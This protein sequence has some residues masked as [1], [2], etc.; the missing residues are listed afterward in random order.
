M[1]KVVVKYTFKQQINKIGLWIFDNEIHLIDEDLAP[2]DIAQVFSSDNKFIGQGYFNPTSKIVI[3][4]LSFDSNEIINATFFKQRITQC[5]QYRQKIGLSNNCRLVFAEGD[6]LPGLIIDKFNDYFVIQIY[7]L[8]M[9]KWKDTIIQIINEIFNPKGIYLRN[10]LPVRVLE[11][12]TEEK[13]SVGKEFNSQI[14]ID[15]HGLKFNVDVAFG[16]KT[17]YFL[18][19]HF[20]RAAIEPFV[21]NADVLSAF[22]YIGSF[23]ILAA[24]FGAKSVIG[25][26]DSAWAVEQATL[27]AE[28]NGLQQKCTF[29]KENA[30]TYLKTLSNEKALF[31]VVMLDPPSFTKSRQRIQ[32][33]IIGYKEINLRALKMIRPGGFLISSSCTNLINE[34]MFRNILFEAAR[35]AKR[36]VQQVYYNTQALDHPILLNM[37][38]TKYLKF[39]VL[40]VS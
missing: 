36:L 1:K 22:S 13:K 21:K 40:K 25:I 9:E 8:G 35:D 7:T 27:N 2:G 4:L 16:Q 29:I 39:I 26:D 17:G 11:G 14:T 19:Q 31:D 24:H 38:Q 5:W 20:N 18:D 12:L 15:E 30:F 32:Q 34:E 28:L 37:P 3:R 6:F 23:E 10:D 33:A